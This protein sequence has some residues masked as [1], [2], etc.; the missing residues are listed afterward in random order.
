MNND[1]V[2][3]PNEMGDTMRTLPQIIGPTEKTLT[4]VL[5]Q[6]GLAGSSMR[7]NEEW[8]AMNRLAASGPIAAAEFA[9]ALVELLGMTRPAAEN[10]IAAMSSQD[11]ISARGGVL[12]LS[13]HG[14][15]ELHA[16]RS[17]VA[18]LTD[19]LERNITPQDRAA[20]ERVLDDLAARARVILARGR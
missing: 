7:S 17:R 16:A 12:Q 14:V 10:L 6:R 2:G 18:A 11:M 20:V 5:L 3:L 9:D 19:E 4:Q 8:V 13:E 15:R 1:T